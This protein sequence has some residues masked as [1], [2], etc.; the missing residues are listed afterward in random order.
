MFAAVLSF[1][2]CLI[3]C[4]GL[5]ANRLRAAQVSIAVPTRV[6]AQR[7]WSAFGVAAVLLVAALFCASL[8]GEARAEGRR[9]ALVIGNADY[10]Q[11]PTLR[12]PVNDVKGISEVLK[13]GGFDVVTGVD[14]D[15]IGLEKTVER[16]FRS[17]DSSDVS[18]FYYSGHAVQIAGVNYIVPVDATLSSAYDIETQTVSLQAVLSF[19]GAHSGTQL[20]F[21]DA[22]RDNPF[23]SGKYWI[24]DKL[25]PVTDKQGLAGLQSSLGT[26]IAYA[27]EPGMVAY[28][29]AADMSP[30]TSALVKRAMGSNDE[31]RRL[32]TTVR[33]DVLEETGGRQRPWESSSLTNDVYLIQQSS[34]P[35]VAPMT[36]L[37]VLAGS[38][39]PITL[40][41][42]EVY[43]STDATVTFD[44]LP[45]VGK[46]LV[47][48]APIEAHKS[49]P[50]ASLLSVTYD[51]G[52]AAE[53][54]VTVAGY[55]AIGSGVSGRRECWR[56]PS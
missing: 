38:V 16:F 26:L 6:R 46:L 32:L 17:L 13:A 54:S 27:T 3:V 8:S 55:T 4:L 19:M 47:D 35:T 30:F 23:K 14:L 15:R 21:L 10:L 34:A 51:P 7:S 20:V 39:S 36:R 52:T 22:C 50:P 24:A 28:D 31:I 48:G 9:V 33:R 53:G 29:G 25:Q 42:P 12:N 49:Y 2:L 41:A 18:L 43:G 45:D 56:S 11:L 44:L 5:A 40:Q 37:S 1:C